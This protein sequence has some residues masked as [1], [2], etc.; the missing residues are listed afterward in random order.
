MYPDQFVADFEATRARAAAGHVDP[1]PQTIELVT[2][3]FRGSTIVGFVHFLKTEKSAWSAQEHADSSSRMKFFGAVA[4]LAGIGA[5]KSYNQAR[6]KE[7]AKMAS[8][9][10][11]GVE[12][13]L[14][15]LGHIPRS[16]ST[17]VET[18]VRELKSVAVADKKADRDGAAGQAQQQDG[19]EATLAASV[20]RA[21]KIVREKPV[22]GIETF[23][24]AFDDYAQ[25]AKMRPDEVGAPVGLNVKPFARADVLALVSKAAFG[26]TDEDDVD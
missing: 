22:L 19:V 10:N 17:L 12:F 14:L 6:A 13:D 5:G 11:I 7:L 4:G 9:A 3:V 8:D 24:T 1:A 18:V 16:R 20:A 21:N 2:E 26:E 25:A 23:M 15:C